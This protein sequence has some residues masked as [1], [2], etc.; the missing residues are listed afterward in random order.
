M[1]GL[2]AKPPWPGSA[3]AAGLASCHVCDRVAPV[4]ERHC[5]RCGAHLH[6]RKKE[7][8]QRTMALL[9]ASM[10]AY[11]PANM[12][13]IM[14]VEQLGG[15]T[16]ANTII[17]GVI[18][19]WEMHA[20]PVAITIFVASV[21]IP[22]LKMIALLWLCAA[23]GGWVRIDGRRL[24]RIYWLTEVVGRWSMVD[25]FVVAVMVTLIQLG[26]LM[27]IHP[28]PAALAFAGVVVLTMLAAMSF[29]PRLLWDRAKAGRKQLRKA[30]EGEE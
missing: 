30:R 16:E 18:T 21:I 9:V 17:G 27:V 4:A 13:P 15:G 29:E 19:F 1:K 14:V 22:I 8:I 5:P 20:Y 26:N 2:V 28:G 6:T 24:T 10:I 3:A 23:A 12:M 25:V 11:V 7:S